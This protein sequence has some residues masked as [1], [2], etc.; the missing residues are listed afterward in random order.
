MSTASGDRP[1]ANS[2]CGL[3]SLAS[4]I[5]VGVQLVELCT[6]Q[7]QAI[8]TKR[9]VSVSG[10]WHAGPQAYVVQRIERTAV[11]QVSAPH[12]ALSVTVPMPKLL[13]SVSRRKGKIVSA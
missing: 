12:Q 11:P 1:K 13:E 4:I 2:A 8:K 5:K 3:I 10:H 6:A 9:D 7:Q